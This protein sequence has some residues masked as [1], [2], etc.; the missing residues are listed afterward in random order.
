MNSSGSVVSVRVQKRNSG[1]SSL[2][3][4]ITPTHLVVVE[5]I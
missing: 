1:R 4:A 5:I 2:L 3:T